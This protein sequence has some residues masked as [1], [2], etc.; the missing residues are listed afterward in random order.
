M[1]Q[2][3]LV[4]SPIYNVAC[5]FTIYVGRPL[6]PLLWTPLEWVF[7]SFIHFRFPSKHLLH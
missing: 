7:F 2:N 5:G 4:L 3:T 1:S 6:F